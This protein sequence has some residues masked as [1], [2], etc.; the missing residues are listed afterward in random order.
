MQNHRGEFRGPSH[1]IARLAL[2]AIAFAAAAGCSSTE[3]KRE[4]AIPSTLCGMAV[5][6]GELE[7][8]LPA[9]SDISVRDTSPVDRTKRCVVRVDGKRAFVAS[10]EWWQQKDDVTTV[11]F[12]HSQVKRGELA[13]QDR[14]LY[15]ETGAVGRT[16]CVDAEL[17]DGVLYVALESHDE[18]S[19]DAQA[20]R[21]LIAS[22]VEAVES[23]DE[24]R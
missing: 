24:C 6:S 18:A 9:G 2:G 22:Y 7:K 8:F 23:S 17:P 11:A 15:S 13:D 4:Y 5:P 19:A 10:R 16:K 20:M 21:K 3:V 14:L 1:L 12:A